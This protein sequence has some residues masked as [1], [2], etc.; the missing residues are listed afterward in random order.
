MLPLPLH[1][2]NVSCVF[3][4]QGGKQCVVIQVAP[5]VSRPR[6]TGLLIFAHAQFAD[7]V[8]RACMDPWQ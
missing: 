1:A 8:R 6:P 5:A 4:G 2:G 3:P 7:S